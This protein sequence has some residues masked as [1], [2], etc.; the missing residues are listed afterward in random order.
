[1]WPF[2]KPLEAKDNPVGAAYMVSSGPVWARQGSKR[3][4]VD[5]GYQMNVIVYRAI[6][7]IVQA[8]VSSRMNGG[9]T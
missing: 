4:Y 9:N 8:A 1:M 6:K 5:E 2:S 3:N 7:E